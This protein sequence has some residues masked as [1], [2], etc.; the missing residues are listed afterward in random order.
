[1]V[2]LLL[3]VH[4]CVNDFVRSAMRVSFQP[5]GNERFRSKDFESA[6]ALYEEARALQPTMPAIHLNLGQCFLELGR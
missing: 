6:L 5:Q 1:M 2:V 4:M 3:C